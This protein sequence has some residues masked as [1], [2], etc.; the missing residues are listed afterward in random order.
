MVREKKSMIGF[1][2]LAWLDSDRAEGNDTKNQSS[3]KS[4]EK[5][6]AKKSVKK[7]ENKKDKTIVY[8]LG[9]NIDETALLK[10]YALL[11][12]TDS[13]VIEKMI[14]DVFSKHGDIKERLEDKDKNILAININNAIKSIVENRHDQ[15]LL[16]GSLL[17][18][19]VSCQS[20]GI[21]RQH[22]SIVTDVFLSAIK[23]SIGRSWTKAISATWNEFLDGLAQEICAAYKD[24]IIEDKNIKL[25]TAVM[26][27]D[28][29][30]GEINQDTSV[31][32][33]GHPVLQLNSVQDI[34]KSQV[35]KND[36]LKLINDNDEIDI[37]ASEVERIDGSALQLLC[38]LFNYA[39]QNNLVI[40]W[41]NPS[42]TFKQAVNTLGMKNI[43]ELT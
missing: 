26:S 38:A 4:Q 30:P 9:K 39:H 35:L 22:F 18:M 36:M 43:L 20:Q 6:I 7:A 33:G 13:G 10:G 1:D 41:I 24:E 19:S 21:L 11:E 28:V 37:D 12:K 25:E 16:D 31:V 32:D 5:S 40:N 2:P 23:E 27:D 42:D 34:S 8:L 17:N 3:E 15:V 29:E 14:A